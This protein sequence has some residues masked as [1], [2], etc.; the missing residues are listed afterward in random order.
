MNLNEKNTFTPQIT[1]ALI[2][3]GIIPFM[4]FV[5][6][7]AGVAMSMIVWSKGPNQ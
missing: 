1:S 5:A 3:C 6:L 2:L 4:G 7:I